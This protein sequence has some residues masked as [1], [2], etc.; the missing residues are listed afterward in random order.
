MSEPST[1]SY[2]DLFD[3]Y[4]PDILNAIDQ[5]EASYERDHEKPTDPQ[6]AAQPRKRPRSPP[7]SPKPERAAT[8][9]QL[10]TRDGSS[11]YMDDTRTYGASKFNGW[12]EY[13]S[14]KR[15]KLQIQN[16]EIPNDDDGGGGVAG[17]SSKIFEGLKIYVRH[18]SGP[19]FPA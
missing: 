13:M 3:E 11:S 10:T 14:R 9:Q 19:R 18:S 17:G 15:A 6:P 1:S 8:L 16:A 7:P 12:G 4:T 2:P 5:V